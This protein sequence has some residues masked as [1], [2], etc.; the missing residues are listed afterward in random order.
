VEEHRQIPITIPVRTRAVEKEKNL[1]QETNPR[2]E[3]KKIQK[4]RISPC[5]YHQK[6]RS[7]IYDYQNRA[8]VLVM[9]NEF[10]QKM[11]PNAE[12]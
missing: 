9:M 1:P 7:S 3:K 6:I 12:R 4:G 5:N 11:K 8:I 10:V 2:S